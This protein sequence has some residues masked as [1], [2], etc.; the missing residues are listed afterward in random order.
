LSWALFSQPCLKQN[1]IGKFSFTESRYARQLGK[2]CES[3]FC[4]KNSSTRK[5]FLIKDEDRQQLFSTFCNSMTWSDRR[6]YVSVLCHLQPTT[7]NKT[8]TNSSRHSGTIK[9]FF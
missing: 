4:K 1:E 6:T 5:C 2:I 7:A 3:T 8:G 9:Y